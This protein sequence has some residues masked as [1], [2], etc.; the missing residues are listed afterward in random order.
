MSAAARLGVY[1]AALAAVFVAAFLIGGAVVPQETVDA[2]T[3]QAED[4]AHVQTPAD[5]EHPA[6]SDH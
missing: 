5:A 4:S 2:W 6:G 3:Q 1:L